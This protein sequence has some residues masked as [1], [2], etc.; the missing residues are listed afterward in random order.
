MTLTLR[1]DVEAL[2][3]QELNSG[4]FRD[5]ND[6]IETALHALAD[7]R[8]FTLA[9]METMIQEAIDEVERGDMVTEQEARTYIAARRAKL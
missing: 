7:S 2:L 4:R 3:Q 9:E 5:P 6:L 8:P 1:P